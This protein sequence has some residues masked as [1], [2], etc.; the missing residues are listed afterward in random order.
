MFRQHL[1]PPTQCGLHCPKTSACTVPGRLLSWLL[2]ALLPLSSM[3]S[4]PCQIAHHCTSLHMLQTTST[5]AGLGRPRQRPQRPTDGV[6]ALISP[7]CSGCE[8]AGAS[9]TPGLTQTRHSSRLA[10]ALGEEAWGSKVSGGHWALHSSLVSPSAQ[11]FVYIQV[12]SHS[13]PGLSVVPP[14]A[15]DTAG[16]GFLRSRA[17]LGWR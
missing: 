10:E 16:L 4:G 5:S 12:Y 14:C 3:P 9:H 1:K 13:A 17:R 11:T 6:G 2:P 15:G 8:A 7:P